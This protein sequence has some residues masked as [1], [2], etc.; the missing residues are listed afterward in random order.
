MVSIEK[1]RDELF[2][3]GTASTSV[4]VI[5]HDV[6]VDINCVEKAVEAVKID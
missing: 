5:K 6:W 2:T 1:S 3:S 4:Y